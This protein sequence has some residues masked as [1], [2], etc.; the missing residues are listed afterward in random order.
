M[1]VNTIAHTDEHTADNVL[2]EQALL[3]D[4][5]AFE[6][7][8]SRYEMT[9]YN[10]VK[11]YL[12]DHEQAW[13]VVQFAFLQLY[14]FLPRLQGNLHSDRSKAPL[15]SWLFQVALNRCRQEKR[16]NQPLHFSDLETFPDE[17]DMS[18]AQG[19]VDPKPLPEELAEQHE[20]EH[21][22]YAAIQEL[23]DRS[24]SVVVLRFTE[25]L[26]FGEIAQRLNMPENTV[27]SHFHRARI[28]LRATLV[29]KAG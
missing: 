18:I 25:E 17:G 22:L 27:K 21:A 26:S 28:R 7:L 6:S 20:L 5:S 8:V 3:G 24:R 16:K 29:Q 14:R 4:Q 1:Y 23:P 19:I 15:K 9:L 10:F 11:R 2:I 13:D 12:G